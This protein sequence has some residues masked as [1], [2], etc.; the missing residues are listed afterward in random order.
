MRKPSPTRDAV[1]SAAATL[2]AA[3][4]PPS[5]T[6]IAGMIGTPVPGV[7]TAI[8]DARRLGLWPYPPLRRS[9][10]PV[11]RI[12]PGIGRSP[13]DPRLLRH[14]TRVPAE[15]PHPSWVYGGPGKP[16]RGGTLDDWRARAGPG[17][18]LLSGPDRPPIYDGPT[19]AEMVREW[20]KLRRKREKAS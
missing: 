4:R 13:N 16:A 18:W 11:P 15:R 8:A 10:D 7:N 3:G 1:L 17:L 9:V 6:T 19:P 14:R 12:A 20:R 2:H 5:P